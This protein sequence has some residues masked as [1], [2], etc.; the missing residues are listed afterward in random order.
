VQRGDAPYGPVVATVGEGQV[1]TITDAGQNAWL[2]KGGK[3]ALYTV[4]G[5]GGYE[6]EGQVLMKHDFTCTCKDKQQLAVPYQIK[7]VTEI[8]TDAGRPV[9]LVEMSDGGAGIG[10]VAVVDFTKNRAVLKRDAAKVVK[11]E[12]QTV[13]IAYYEGE[14]AWNAVNA[15]KQ[16]TPVKTETLDM[17]QALKVPT[18]GI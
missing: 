18:V 13:D 1:K 5:T 10:H 4:K 12:G 15:G 3:C 9:V 2:M 11:V 6:N 17:S 7:V 14:A 8:E 16:A